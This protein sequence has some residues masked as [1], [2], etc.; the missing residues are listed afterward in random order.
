MRN[1]I[2]RILEPTV[3]SPGAVREELRAYLEEHGLEALVPTAT[4]LVSELVANAVFHAAGDIEV[5][6]S[7][8]GHCLR[9][10]VRDHNPALPET[11]SPDDDDGGHGLHIVEGFATSWGS[12][13]IPDGGK[14]TWFELDAG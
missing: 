2:A 8:D 11:R 1:Q 14:V 10:E 12:R 6:V 4:L 5:S 7:F 3:E 9:V 13:V